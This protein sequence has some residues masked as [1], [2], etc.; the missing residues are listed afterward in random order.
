MSHMRSHNTH[1]E[2]VGHVDVGDEPP[3]APEQRPILDAK[4]RLA[5]HDFI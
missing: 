3:L 2:L 5:D 4:Y 1:V